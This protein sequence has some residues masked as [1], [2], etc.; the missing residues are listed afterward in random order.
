MVMAMT[1]KTSHTRSFGFLLLLSLLI[2]FLLRTITINDGSVAIVAASSSSSS[3]FSAY[4]YPRARS[5]SVSGTTS[6]TTRRELGIGYHHNSNKKKHHSPSPPKPYYKR[7]KYSKK[8]SKHEYY[9]P[10][11]KLPKPMPIPPKHHGHRNRYYGGNYYQH[12]KP[13]KKPNQ[14]THKPINKPTQIPTK[15]TKKPQNNKSN[16]PS[17]EP[18]TTIAVPIE[19]GKAQ[20]T[21]VP[22]ASETAIDTS[23]EDAKDD[24]TDIISP[25]VDPKF[26][27]P[28]VPEE[29]QQDVEAGVVN[30]VTEEEEETETVEEVESEKAEAISFFFPPTNSPTDKLSPPPAALIPVSQNNIQA[31]KE[32]IPLITEVV[33]L[34]EVLEESK[35]EDNTTT[36]NEK[37]SIV[38]LRMQD[39]VLNG[40]AEFDDPASYQSLALRRVEDQLFSENM[41]TIKLLQYYVLYCIYEATNSKPNEYII[42]SGVFDNNSDDG[43]VTIPGWTVTTGWLEID[44]DPCDG[45]WHGVVCDTTGI[46]RQ[47]G[48]NSSNEA[49]RVINLDLFSNGLTGNF[50]PEVV[51]LSGDGFYATGA[52][53]LIAIDIFNNEY[54]SNF[55]DNSWIADM[56]SQLGYLYFQDTMFG[57]SLP[58]KFPDGLIELDIANSMITGILDGAAFKDLNALRFL[59]MDGLQ[60]NS[61]IPTEIAALPNLE[62]LFASD[63]L[64]TGD[65]SYMGSMSSIFEHWVDRNSGLGGTIP[66]F[67]GQLSTLQ[68]FSIAECNFVGTIPESLGDL[69]L[70]QQMWMF[71]NQ[72]TGEIPGSIGNLKFMRIFEV[73]GNNLSDSMPESVCENFQTGMLKILGADCDDGSIDCPC[74]T[75]CSVEECRPQI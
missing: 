56:G 2:I 43:Q 33:D 41:S 22:T 50:P 63:S 9:Y 72:L 75:C 13:T 1:T 16:V 4:E 68:S 36:N 28:R 60:F 49:G 59:L 65:L 23:L 61:T 11:P 64:I 42:Q 53:A 24:S 31:D 14:T 7:H 6:K 25:K 8:S 17:Y 48:D 3:I 5:G 15:P 32:Q 34:V 71:S 74:C 10:H 69:H 45:N 57:G 21:S 67:I 30:L 39:F 35:E 29:Q 51:L 52:G 47:Q 37:Q 26:N 20:S 18:T 46:E 58:S 66:N 27:L 55:N 62:Y 19:Q 38:Q 70:M 54:L 73:E 12:K 40:G 44:S